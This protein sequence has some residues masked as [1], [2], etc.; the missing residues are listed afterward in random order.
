VKV[1]K[2]PPAAAWRVACLLVPTY[3]L[4]DA[5]SLTGTQLES[6]WRVSRPSDD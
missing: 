5:R 4:E 6:L 2:A 1:V 3:T